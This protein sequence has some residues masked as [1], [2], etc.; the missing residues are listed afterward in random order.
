MTDAQL[1]YDALLRAERRF[2]G[3]D[4]RGV[5]EVSPLISREAATYALIALNVLREEIGNGLMKEG[6]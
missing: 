5:P 3:I 2:D 6:R 4:T 1:I